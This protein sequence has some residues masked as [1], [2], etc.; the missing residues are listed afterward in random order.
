MYRLADQWN[1]I[2]IPFSRDF[3]YGPVV[4]ILCASSGGGPG[5]IPDQGTKILYAV[6][7]SQYIKKSFVFI[8]KEL[9]V[10][11]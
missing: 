5:S 9:R 3:P 2:D 7:C 1:R 10:Q 6:Q 4:K 8:F 11:K